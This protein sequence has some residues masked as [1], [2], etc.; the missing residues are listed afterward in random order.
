[1]MTRYTNSLMF[2]D[3]N[4]DL[5]SLLHVN[6]YD[7]RIVSEYLSRILGSGHAVLNRVTEEGFTHSSIH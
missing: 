7:F 2:G 5:L 6:N 1:M 3:Y 4:Y